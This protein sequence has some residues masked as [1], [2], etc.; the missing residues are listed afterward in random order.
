MKSKR[1]I[2]PVVTVSYILDDGCGAIESV[3]GLHGSYRKLEIDQSKGKDVL[4]AKEVAHVAKMLGQYA[5]EAVDSLSIMETEI[6]RDE[7]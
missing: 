2:Y 4:T 5:E 7:F 6:D 3:G 1:V